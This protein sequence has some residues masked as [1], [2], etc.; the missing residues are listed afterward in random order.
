MLVQCFFC[1]DE[2][3]VESIAKVGMY[4]HCKECG[5]TGPDA[6]DEGEAVAKWLHHR[7][8]GVGTPGL[9]SSVM[10]IC[11]GGLSVIRNNVH[12][13]Q[14]LGMSRRDATYIASKLARTTVSPLILGDQH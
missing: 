1:G 11:G 3:V 8:P 14:N 13:L 6:E 10:L 7:R 4:V 5:A 2:A 12:T 9:P